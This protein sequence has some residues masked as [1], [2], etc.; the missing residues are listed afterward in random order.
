MLSALLNKQLVGTLGGCNE[1]EEFLCEWKSLK[2]LLLF[3]QSISNQQ[4]NCH[5]SCNEISSH[6]DSSFRSTLGEVKRLLSNG[7]GDEMAGIT[8]AFIS[9]IMCVETDEILMNLPSLMVISHNLRGL[10]FSLL[11][12]VFFLDHSVLFHAIKLW[13]QM[14][15]TGM[16]MAISNPSGGSIDAALVGTLYAESIN[17]HQLFDTTEVDAAAFSLFLKQAPFHVLFPAMMCMNGPYSSEVSKMQ[18]LLLDKLSKGTTD[19]SLFLNLRLVLHWTHQI[20]SY[21]KLNPSV[22]TEQLS[23]LCVTLVKKLLACL[24]V[25]ESGSDCSTGSS[26]CSSSHNIQEVAKTI[27]SH[28]SVLMSL[29]FPLGSGP[30]FANENVVNSFDVLNILSREG[31]HNFSNPILNILTTTLD[32]VWSIC[33][34]HLCAT[35]ARDVTYKELVKAFKSLQQRLFLEVKDRFEQCACTK[36]LTPFLQTFYTLHALLKFLSP[37]LLLE[38]VDWMFNRVESDDLIA[39]NSALSVGCSLAAGAFS[40]LSFYLQQKTR[41]RVP[42]DLFWEMSEKNM[43]P[44]MFEQIYSKIVNFAIIFE[45]DCADKCLLEAVSVLYR[46]KQMQQK[47]FHPLVLAMCRIIMITP[48][49]MLSHCIHKTNI[50]RAKFLCM[51]SDMSS[52]HSSIF[53]HLFWGLLNRSLHHDIS[54]MG[55]SFDLTLSERHY[56]LLLPA[57]L[58]Y[59][60][61]ISL[62][63][64]EQ[65]HKDFKHVPYFYSKILLKGFSQW[66][67]FVFKDIFE[68]D[69]R[70]FFPSS[71]K[72]LLYLVDD[73]LLGKSLRMLQYH[74]ALNGDSIT[75]KKRLKLFKS[76]YPISASHDEMLDC[77]CQ[78]IDCYSLHQSLN[79]INR[80]V[81]KISLC[82]ILLFHGK[83]E[84]DL[85][86]NASEMGSKMEASRIR[87]INILVEIWHFLVKNFSLASDPSGSG[88]SRNISSPY[89]YLEVFLLRNIL[90]VVVEMRDYLI[91]LQCIPFLEQ[92][93]RSALLYRFH[94]PTTLKILQVLL[95]QLYEGKLSYDLYLQLLLAHSQFAPTLHSVCKLSHSL[96]SDYYLKPVS[97]ILRCLVFPPLDHYETDGPH[98]EKTI[99]LSSG[100]LEIV[101]L[102]RI[103]LL[104]NAHQCGL[105]NDSGINYKE[106]HTLLCHSYGATLSQIDLNIYKLMQEI[107]YISKSV[108]KNVVNA[109]CLWGTAALKVKIEHPLEQNPSNL[110]VDSEEITEWSRS[111][112]R[113]SIPIDPEICTSTVLFFP[114][115]RR[116]GDELLSVTKIQPDNVA[117]MAEVCVQV[118]CICVSF[119]SLPVLLPLFLTNYLKSYADMFF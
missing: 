5:F 108:S 98:D 63:L 48:V 116:A 16:D 42:Y 34:T 85:K 102:L 93:T 118:V 80:I 72:E 100:Q 87:F 6:P 8:T 49:K 30:K 84:G 74:F 112:H 103:L 78:V 90:S 110:K 31:V 46:R 81:G 109:E 101:K 114:Y 82:K 2:N 71:V 38:L 36:Y 77:D 41:N 33:S 1:N 95:T 24:A 32:Y 45:I 54:G 105:G 44:N 29:S 40:A 47:K 9:S 55:R 57:S 10:P 94:D 22:E 20:Q 83:A 12:S 64:G 62:R 61:S 21:Q 115:D 28:P 3:A 107:E 119:V 17:C 89:N 66:K 11:S 106:L 111:Q 19:C 25:P 88:K 65:N 76:I 4:S 59:L 51:L 35:K 7:G 27:F 67:S 58:S 56:I 39:R 60:N 15:H 70:E 53:G 92:L 96:R 79:I 68:E 73:S 75:L 52:L 99:E 117:K 37:F 97:S 104:K 69:Y 50:N 86:D 23:N 13:P 91:Q 113:E 43:K 18:E 26:F 14:F